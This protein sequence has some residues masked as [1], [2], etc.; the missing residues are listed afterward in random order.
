[1]AVVRA[2][3]TQVAWTGDKESMIVRHEELAREAAADGVQIIGF[4]E[5][6]YG[7]YFGAVQDQK[8]YDYVESIPGPDGRAFPGR[9]Q[10]SSNMAIVLPIYEV[11]NAGEYYN[12]AADDRR[13]RLAARHLPQAPHP[14]PSGVLGE[15]LLPSRQRRLPGLRDRGRAHRH[16]HLL[17]PALPRGLA[18][19][20][21]EQRAARVQPVNATKPRAVQPAVGARAAR[22]RPRPTS[23]SC[24]S[25]QPDRTGGRASSASRRPALLRLV[26]LRRPARQLRRRASPRP[27]RRRC[28]SPATST[29]TSSRPCATTGSST[30]TADPSPTPGLTQP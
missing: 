26:L 29:S 10:V 30:A 7:P 15:V 6:F 11:A 3:I 22:A 2:A 8:Y 23:T 14:E 28:W 13:R 12:T 16:L 25:Q 21:P 17:R 4:Q 18:R 24:C 20:R 9:R 1:M 5:L 27:T 19:A